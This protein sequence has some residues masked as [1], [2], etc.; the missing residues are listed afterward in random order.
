MM[1]P[2]TNPADA[3][4]Y[5]LFSGAPRKRHGRSLY[6]APRPPARKRG[7]LGTQAPIECPDAT[8]HEII[9]GL[10]VAAKQL[11]FTIGQGG[12]YDRTTG[13][14]TVVGKDHVTGRAGDWKI[15]GRVVADITK[16]WRKLHPRLPRTPREMIAR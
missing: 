7:V 5:K 9:T 3:T 4:V 16:E 12:E 8:P 11:G 15:P 14:Y 1:T 2:A 13:Y 6:R 10:C